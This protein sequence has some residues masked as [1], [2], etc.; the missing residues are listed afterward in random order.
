[1]AELELAAAADMAA[2]I[3]ERGKAAAEVVRFE[4]KALAAGWAKAVDAF[5]EGDEYARWVMLKKLA[6]S[7]RKMMVNTADSPI[8]DIFRQYEAQK[9][10]T[11]TAKG[12]SS[13][14][15]EVTKPTAVPVNRLEVDSKPEKAAKQEAAELETESVG[16][17]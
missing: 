17:Q 15:A 7:Y 12:S 9:A 16:G 2:A 8:M 3:T 13:V 1:M 6:P 4:N 10:S 11:Q 5:G 14:P